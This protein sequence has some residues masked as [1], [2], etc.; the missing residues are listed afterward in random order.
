M[1]QP[2]YMKNNLIENPRF[3]LIQ[4]FVRQ[5]LSLLAHNRE[6]YQAISCILPAN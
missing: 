2:F 4:A 5:Y 1:S 3:R 6:S